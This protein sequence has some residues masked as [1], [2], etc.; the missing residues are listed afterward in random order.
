M[1]YVYDC[2]GCGVS[3]EIIKH[4]TK[5]DDPEQCPACKTLGERRFMPSRV[6]FSKT[7]VEHAEYNPGLGCVVKSARDRA[8]Q[9]KRRGL[10]EVGNDYS[11][12]H[13]MLKEQDRAVEEKREKA[14]E[15]AHVTAMKEANQ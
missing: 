9:A 5:M 14:W 15:S 2:P 7:R 11:D 4:H 6:F 10:V 1:T 12:G 3:F 13:S 8:E